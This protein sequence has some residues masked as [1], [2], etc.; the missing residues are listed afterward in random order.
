MCLPAF[1]RKYLVRNATATAEGLQSALHSHTLYLVS[2]IRN[3]VRA[4]GPPTPKAQT[5]RWRGIRDDAS[6]GWNGCADEVS[7]TC[8]EQSA[9]IRITYHLRMPYCMILSTRATPIPRPAGMKGSRNEA[10]L[11]Y[12]PAAVTTKWRRERIRI[13]TG[14]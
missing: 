14:Y 6:R 9:R 1:T 10:Q 2:Y 7:M 11:R 4:Q 13:P 5:D 3:L 12:S 8:L